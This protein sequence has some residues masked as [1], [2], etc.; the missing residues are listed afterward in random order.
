MNRL[1]RAIIS[2][3]KTHIAPDLNIYIALYILFHFEG[4]GGSGG[5]FSHHIYNIYISIK[6]MHKKRGLHSIVLELLLIKYCN[7]SPFRHQ[8]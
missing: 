2:M 3:K 1:A 5:D 4:G 6:L 8:K 7:V